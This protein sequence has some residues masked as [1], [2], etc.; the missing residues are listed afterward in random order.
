MTLLFALL[1]L[2]LFVLALVPV[3]KVLVGFYGFDQA[4]GAWALLFIVGWVL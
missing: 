2:V 1:V 4:L 3:F